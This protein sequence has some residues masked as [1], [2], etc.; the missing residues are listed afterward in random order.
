MPS[1][2]FGLTFAVIQYADG[3][4]AE[5]PSCRR[6]RSSTPRAAATPR[7]STLP[8]REVYAEDIRRGQPS[9]YRTPTANFYTPRA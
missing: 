9:A 6:Q 2:P 8:P 5:G 3:Q 4:Y 1:L 7:A